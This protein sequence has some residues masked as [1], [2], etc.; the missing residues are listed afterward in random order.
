[1]ATFRISSWRASASDT[2][3]ESRSHILVEPSLSVNRKVTVPVGGPSI[4]SPSSS[5][6]LG[7]NIAAEHCRGPPFT[8]LAESASQPSLP[9]SERVT[10]GT[11]TRVL[12]SHNPPTSVSRRC[13]RLQDRLIQA[14]FLAHGCPP[15]LRVA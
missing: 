5:L 3:R 2:A 15:F 6:P 1:M 4:T 13:C 10:D 11:R 12:R 7:N 8:R 14:Y 9:S